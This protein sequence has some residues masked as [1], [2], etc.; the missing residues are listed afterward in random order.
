MRLPKVEPH[1]PLPF[2][3]SIKSNHKFWLKFAKL[4]VSIGDKLS[5]KLW[6]V[7]IGLGEE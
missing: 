7:S 1:T 5:G 6:S 3:I 4:L 2:Q